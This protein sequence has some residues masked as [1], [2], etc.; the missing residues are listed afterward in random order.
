MSEALPLPREMEAMVN[1]LFTRYKTISITRAYSDNT[2]S[3]LTTTSSKEKE[4]S[5]LTR[6]AGN[7]N[8]VVVFAVEENGFVYVLEKYCRCINGCT[9]QN[10]KRV[11]KWVTTGQD[12]IRILLL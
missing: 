9:Y 12:P 10:C 7:P 3:L 11:K 6:H 4:S 5:W 8:G 2:A 1:W